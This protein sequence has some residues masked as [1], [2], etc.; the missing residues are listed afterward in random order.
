MAFFTPPLFTPP[1]SFEQL[2]LD[3][4]AL[5]I[6][7]LVLRWYSL[8][9]IAGILVAWW[10]LGR[11]L[12]RPGA[13]F[14]RSNLDDLV[15]WCTLGVILGGRLAYV[16]FYDL[17][18]YLSRP[19][20]IFQLWEGGMS[21]H[22]GLLGVGLAV[23]LYARKHQ[24]PLLRS[25]DYMAAVAPFGLMLGRMANFIN[26]ELWGRPTD[27]TWGVIFPYA[28]PEPRHPSQIYEALA[29]G[30]LLFVV[31][32]LLFWL[33]RARFK[34]GLLTG[35]FL[36]GYG[37]ARFLI[38]LVREPDSQLGVLGYGLTMGQTLSLPLILL[39]LW[40]LATTSRREQVAP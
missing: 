21:F 23:F 39:G 5:S 34:S 10:L 38:E 33:T 40:L 29:E 20:A 28:G 15:A 7:P 11:M 26:G 19:L 9:Y 6:G 13:P 27:G 14:T 3:P 24:L 31:L 17:G 35:L 37:V 8:A 25:F 36:T 1:V 18:S 12:R 22:G 4:I 16:L 2:G 30:L 32:Q